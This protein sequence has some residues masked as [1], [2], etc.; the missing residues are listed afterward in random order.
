MRSRS[1]HAVD[2]VPPTSRGRTNTGTNSGTKNRPKNA[3]KT[4]RHSTL[5]P[6]NPSATLASG[7]APNTRSKKRTKNRTDI[8]HNNASTLSEEALV[9]AIVSLRMLAHSN[10]IDSERLIA[11]NAADLCL[12]LVHALRLGDPKELATPTRWLREFNKK[13]GFQRLYDDHPDDT[14]DAQIHFL[15]FV[16]SAYRRARLRLQEDA[17]RA[18]ALEIWLAA[19]NARYASFM[20]AQ[21]RGAT[22]K[23]FYAAVR[24]TLTK[25][26][27]TGVKDA[28]ELGR[29]VLRA[30][31]TADRK[32]QKLFKGRSVMDWNDAHDDLLVK[33]VA[34]VPH[35]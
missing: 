35:R 11:R 33:D 1:K 8:G 20:P 16:A 27:R 13:H 4:P 5:S 24:T 22:E 34:T 9:R 3:E 12:G 21:P 6:H 28:I 2:A 19:S 25:A 30:L 23:N 10:A 31:G 26:H 29:A 15:E 17:F 18:A 32:V 14:S 7:I